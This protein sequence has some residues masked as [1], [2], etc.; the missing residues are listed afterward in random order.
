MPEKKPRGLARVAFLERLETIR[1]ELAQGWT[2]QAIYDRLKP[3]IGI[4]I[5]YQH[6]ARYCAQVRDGLPIGTGAR[7]GQV[8]GMIHRDRNATVTS[9]T[10]SPPRGTPA[11]ARHQSAARSFRHDPV[12]R[13]DDRK[14]LLGEE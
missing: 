3:E 4:V 12:E 11:D 7:A 9:S 14:R 1:A 5:S 10:S 8:R 13:P 2:A 6:F